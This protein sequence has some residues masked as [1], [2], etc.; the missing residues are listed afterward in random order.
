MPQGAREQ[1]LREALQAAGLDEVV[2][3]LP[4]HVLLLSGYWPMN[5]VSFAVLPVASDPVL[6]VPEGERRW[7]EAG[8]WNEVRTFGWGNV[9][10]PPPLDSVVG[11]LRDLRLGLTGAGHHVRLGYEGSA[12]SIAPAYAAGESVA[13]AEPTRA[14]LQSVFGDALV[15]AT[16]LLEGERAVKTPDELAGVR[17]A[18]AAADLG[19][20]ALAECLRPGVTECEMAT[21]AEGAVVYR[22]LDSLGA[23][24]IRAWA[25]VLA[26]PSSAEAWLPFQ[27]PRVV[28]IVEGELAVLELGV[29]ADGFWADVTRTYV[30]G[31]PSARQWQIHAI[32]LAAQTA[33]VAA[34][35]PG[36]TGA[37]VDRAARQVIE[38]AG[39]GYAFHHQTGHGLG[40]R[41]H[42]ALPLLHPACD[43]PLAAGMVTSVEPGIY[44][45][46]EFGLRI[47]DD[48]LVTETGAELLSRAPRGLIP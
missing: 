25:T 47:E 21:A 3:R 20:A 32:V 41:Y 17:R 6:I 35:R 12:E 16:T 48:V 8:R 45:P 40:F 36:V 7:A 24:R 30:A 34:I 31:E 13:V 37:E 14:M 39:L 42:E 4:E 38:A 15:D 1:R 33:A 2:C 27:V 9:D 10:S 46:G 11:H 44:L 18:V 28:P 5:G 29:V 43:R 22:A 23:S 26:G 19:C